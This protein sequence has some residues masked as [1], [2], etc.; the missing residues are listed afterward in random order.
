VINKNKNLSG[1]YFAK[2]RNIEKFDQNILIWNL[3]VKKKLY[4]FLEFDP[5]LSA[6]NRCCDCPSRLSLAQLATALIIIMF[7]MY[8]ILYIVA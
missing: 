6:E 8:L 5:M 7:I 1:P 2:F 3:V 4:L